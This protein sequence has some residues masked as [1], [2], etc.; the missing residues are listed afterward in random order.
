M[1]DHSKRIRSEYNLWRPRKYWFFPIVFKFSGH[2]VY[3]NSIVKGRVITMSKACLL[4]IKSPIP[5]E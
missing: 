4:K 5:T 1:P 2:R 3:E